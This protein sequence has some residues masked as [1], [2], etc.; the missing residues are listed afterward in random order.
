[1][2]SGVYLLSLVCAHPVVPYVLQVLDEDT[3]GWTSAYGEKW[4]QC[5]PYFDSFAYVTNL[6]YIC[7]K[8]AYV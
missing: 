5:P 3:V 6:V 4:L 8:N 1:M 2:N 7:I